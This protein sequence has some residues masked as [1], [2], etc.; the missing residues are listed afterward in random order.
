MK[1][2]VSVDLSEKGIDRLIKKLDEYERWLKRKSDALA[3]RLAAL[4][5]TSASIGFASALYDGDRNVQISVERRGDSQY[6]VMANGESVL[7]I[8]FGAGITMADTVHP[9]AAEKGM[10]PGTWP[11]KHY[12]VNSGGERVAN[13]ENDLGWYLPKEKGGG[14]T[15]GNPANMPMYFSVRNLEQEIARIVREVFS[16]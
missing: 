8:E 14:H 15:Y 3:A 7:F 4:G 6:A 13:W 2:T 10:G 12:S 1:H 5:A 11:D 9:E 16:D